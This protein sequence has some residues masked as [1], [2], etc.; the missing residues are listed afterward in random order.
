MSL[1]QKKM[2]LLLLVLSSTFCTSWASAGCS[3]SEQIAA[4]SSIINSVDSIVSKA[5]GSLNAFHNLAE[6]FHVAMNGPPSVVD[7]PNN[8]AQASIW[9]MQNW[10]GSGASAT[11]IYIGWEDNTFITYT[12][13]GNL[14]Y[15][16]ACNATSTCVRREYNVTDS[17]G[18][19]TS[20]SAYVERRYMASKRPW[21][22]VAKSACIIDNN[23]YVTCPMVNTP[24]YPDVSTLGLYLT[25][26]MGIPNFRGK[27]LFSFNQGVY[28]YG[29]QGQTTTTS[30]DVSGLAGVVAVDIPCSQFNTVLEAVVAAEA[31]EG[32]VAYIMEKGTN[33]L[34]ATSDGSEVAVAD[35]LFIERVSAQHSSTV[36][37]AKS[38]EFIVI[39]SYLSDNTFLWNDF[40]ITTRKYF[41]N[42]LSWYLVMVS[43]YTRLRS[44]DIKSEPLVLSN[45]VYTVHSALSN[46]IRAGKMIL[47]GIKYNMYKNPLVPPRTATL[48]KYGGSLA[49]TN[50]Q[51]MLIAAGKSFPSAQFIYIG[52]E[53]DTFVGYK[54]KADN[55]GFSSFQYRDGAIQNGEDSERKKYYTDRMTGYVANTTYVGAS[56]VVK[57][58]FCS[59]RPWYV[60]AK[61]ARKPVWSPVY[62]YDSSDGY[63]LGTTYALPFYDSSGNLVGVVGIDWSL[64]TAQKLIAPF[65]TSGTV[66]YAME[67]D[68]SPQVTSTDGITRSSNFNLLMTSSN[69]NT[70]N[71]DTSSLVKAYSFDEV[72]DYQVSYTARYLEKTGM[73]EDSYFSIGNLDC[74]VVNYNS[75]G[76]NWRFVGISYQYPTS[77]SDTVANDDFIDEVFNDDTTQ[78][79]KILNESKRGI[80]AV[81]ILYV[82]Q[83]VASLYALSKKPNI[84][85]R[86]YLFTAYESVLDFLYTHIIQEPLQE[87]EKKQNND[88]E[89]YQV[90]KDNIDMKQVQMVANPLQKGTDDTDDTGNKD[91][92]LHE[93]L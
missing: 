46:I 44:C 68:Q 45:L 20:A 18:R 42:S 2:L 50:V 33:Y 59:K 74:E 58:Y 36:L 84:A 37:I 24:L 64:D 9:D 51:N 72:Q 21:Y 67:T 92:P 82:L 55:D 54:L 10:E 38:S 73:T 77:S 47:G 22:T 66:Y 83:F 70:I 62:A 1:D 93:H 16:N 11:N 14:I 52:Y 32:S 43:P 49:I 3:M 88:S 35:G 41:K 87:T 91:D 89:A 25:P 60:A 69:A 63:K 40:I 7:D 8:I 19:T 15:A 81:I 5:A 48:W 26:S 6:S 57:D 78:V 53:D 56:S 90:R 4:V 65:A 80:A 71:K 28:P 39:N 29:L 27:P 30:T 75:L 34:V 61:E 76:L 12:D 13:S 79:Q 86:A 23:K 85:L 17:E 31:G